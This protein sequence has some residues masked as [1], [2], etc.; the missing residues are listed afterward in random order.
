MQIKRLTQPWTSAR[1]HGGGS[2]R[3]FEEFA[4]LGVGSV[5]AALSPLTSTPEV[6]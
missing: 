1:V 3:V 2:R 4:W 6:A 5:K